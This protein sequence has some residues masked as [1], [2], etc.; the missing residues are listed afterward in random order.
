MP[1][2]T[3]APSLPPTAN[4]HEVRSSREGPKTKVH[5]DGRNLRNVEKWS[6]EPQAV[7]DSGWETLPISPVGEYL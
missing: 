4:L 7:C 1:G 5:Q 3:E 6:N 2:T